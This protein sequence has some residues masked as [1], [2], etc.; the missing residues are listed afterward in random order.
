[1]TVVAAQT[2][3]VEEYLE[4][5]R[6]AEIRHEYVDG[7]LLPMPDTTRTHGH[8][9]ANILVALRPTVLARGCEIQASDVM[10][11]TQGTRFR[12]PDIVVSCN[13]GSDPY[14]LENPC[15][16]AEIT[17]DSTADTDHGR[18]LEEY[19]K[20]PSLERYAIISQ[21]QR[22]VIVY[23]LVNGAWT[24]ETHSDAGEFGIPC[25]SANLSLD[26]IYAGVAI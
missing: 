6:R 3:T 5:E 8:M 14:L 7:T 1:M 16:I 26:Q 18:K 9:V 13:P 17:S 23:K 11:R 20:L 12:Y 4:S 15:F 2:L 25:L 10:T 21:A 24:F 22:F 19:T